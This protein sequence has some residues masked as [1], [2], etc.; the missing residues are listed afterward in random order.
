MPR[1]YSNTR[2]HHCHAYGHLKRTCPSIK[3]LHVGGISVYAKG[4]NNTTTHHRKIHEP[5]AEKVVPTICIP[6]V[7]QVGYA[8]CEPIEK[9]PSNIGMKD[10]F[11]FNNLNI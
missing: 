10:N 9:R 3:R 7:F 4:Q 5:P 8:V 2:C 11:T 6:S 1:D